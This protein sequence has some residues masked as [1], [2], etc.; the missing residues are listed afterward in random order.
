MVFFIISKWYAMTCYAWTCLQLIHN[1]IP[2]RKDEHDGLGQAV[3]VF[4]PREL[5][6]TLQCSACCAEYKAEVSVLCSR[7]LSYTQTQTKI[8]WRVFVVTLFFCPLWTFPLS[9][10]TI[11]NHA[12]FLCGDFESAVCLSAQPPLAD[13]I[14]TIWVVGGTQVYKVNLTTISCPNELSDSHV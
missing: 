14:E 6:P 13:L 9:Y 11:P 8:F 7:S 2:S 10:R 3:L 4:Q 5:V 1:F 12:H